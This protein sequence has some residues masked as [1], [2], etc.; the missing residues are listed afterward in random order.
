VSATIEIRDHPIGPCATALSDDADADVDAGAL[1]RRL[2]RT[3]RRGQRDSA[4]SQ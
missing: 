3:A 1:V 2:D 4:A